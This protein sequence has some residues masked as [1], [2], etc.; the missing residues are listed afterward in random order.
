MLRHFQSRLIRTLNLLTDIIRVHVL[1][2][3][4]VG[5]FRADPQ[6]VEATL[7]FLRVDVQTLLLDGWFNH[8]NK[9]L[10]GDNLIVWGSTQRS[11][12]DS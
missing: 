5:V 2:C 12:N 1:M 4:A 6:H 7:V 8:D 11:S 10:S 9:F 3:R